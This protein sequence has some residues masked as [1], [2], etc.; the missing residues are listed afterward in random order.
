MISTDGTFIGSLA[1]L[2]LRFLA[3]F[4]SSYV[5]KFKKAGLTANGFMH[6]KVLA[7]F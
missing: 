3:V 7:F 6:G 5:E 4:S 1:Q 2:I